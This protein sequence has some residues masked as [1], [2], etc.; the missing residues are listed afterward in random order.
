MYEEESSEEESEEEEDETQKILSFRQYSREEDEGDVPEVTPPSLILSLPPSL[1]PPP[2]PLI[3][4]RPPSFLQGDLG[5]GA[6]PSRGT[7]SYGGYL[8][9]DDSKESEL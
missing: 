5:L 9:L 8:K 1:P 3:S 4:P 2:A 7:S 6:E